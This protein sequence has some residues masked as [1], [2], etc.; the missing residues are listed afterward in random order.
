MPAAHGFELH[1]VRAYRMMG[2]VSALSRV[3]SVALDRMEALKNA[4]LLDERGEDFVP[5]SFDIRMEDV[6][7]SYDGTRLLEGSI[8]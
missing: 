2:S 4:P 7:F 3:I 5:E 6:V 1:A 8:L